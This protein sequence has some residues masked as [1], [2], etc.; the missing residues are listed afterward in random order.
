MGMAMSH[1]GIGPWTRITWAHASWM[2]GTSSFGM[3]AAHLLAALLCGLWLAHGERAAF[4]ILRAVAGWLAAPLRLL[5]APARRR[6][7]AR[8][9]ACAGT[10]RTGRRGCSFSSTRSPLGGRPPGPLSSDDSWFPEAVRHAPRAR[11]YV[12][13][14]SGIGRAHRARATGRRPSP[15]TGTAALPACPAARAG[16]AAVRGAGSRMTREGHQVITPAL[17]ASRDLTRRRRQ[18][19]RTSRSP[20]GRWPPAAATPTPST[21]SYAP[22]T[23]TSRATS[24]TSPPTPRPPT[25]WPRTRSCGRSAACTGSRAAPRPAPGCCPSPAAR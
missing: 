3:L 22:C 24:P 16:R 18:S 6:R 5:L 12:R 10:V 19:G 13:T 15:L 2:G 8:A 14:G 17:P 7:T 1:M 4:R 23:A 11:S 9:S 20:P 25:T 21:T